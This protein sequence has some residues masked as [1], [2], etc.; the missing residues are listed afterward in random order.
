MNTK[1]NYID[2]SKYNTKPKT[3]TS[4]EQSEP[5]LLSQLFKEPSDSDPVERKKARDARFGR[6]SQNTNIS[7][8]F[9]K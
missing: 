5:T 1:K 8:S 2:L 3:N 6:T 7:G 9:S 4:D